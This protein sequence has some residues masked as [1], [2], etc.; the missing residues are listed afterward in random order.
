MSASDWAVEIDPIFFCWRWQ[1]RRDKRD[2]RALM[3]IAG[4]TINAYRVIYEAEV[5]PVPEGLVLDHTCRRA[6]CCAPYHL[7]P[8]TKSENERRKH[9]RHM[10]RIHRCKNGHD[11][12]LHAAVT[13]EGGK[14]CRACGR[15]ANGLAVGGPPTRG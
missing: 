15:E 5:G 14:A 11:L 9:W 12:R 7:E 1:G 8:V 6:D 13:P 3:Y 2:N 10:A 4:R